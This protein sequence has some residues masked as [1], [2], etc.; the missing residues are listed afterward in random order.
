MRERLKKI[1]RL[2]HKDKKTGKE[3]AGIDQA[4]DQRD[5]TT[6][7]KPL[8]SSQ[9]AIPP[10]KSIEISQPKD[11]WQ[12]AYDQ[13]DEKQQQILLR[14][15]SSSELKDKKAG[16]RELVDEIIHVTKL[17]YEAYQQKSDTTLR[18]TSR[19]IIDALL[20]YKD[21]INAVAVLDLTHHAASAWAVV[22][23]GLEVC[24]ARHLGRA[25]CLLSDWYRR[26][27]R[28]TMTHEMHCLNHRSTWPMS[29]HNAPLSNRD[30]I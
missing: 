29:L 4:E 8:T 23:F 13:L 3:K 28:L 5:S 30:F 15:Q 26:S 10:L 11:L 12:T 2:L 9:A 24:I 21:F 18:K 19:K 14:T 17:Q 1:H 6:N 22:L 25:S 20:S 16:S 27:P 7:A